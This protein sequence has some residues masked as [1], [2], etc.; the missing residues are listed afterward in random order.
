MEK[1]ISVDDS[2]TF[3]P[4]VV[5]KNTLVRNAL[6]VMKKYKIRHLPVVEKNRVIGIV[7]E[8]DVKSLTKTSGASVEEIMVAHPYRVKRGQLLTEVAQ[9]MAEKKYG[10]AIIENDKNEVIGIFT[11]TDALFLLSRL[12]KESEYS[13][14]KIEQINWSKFPKYM[15]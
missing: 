1:K 12:L 3:Y 7:S 9:K 5:F 6:S 15:I 2:M 8:R 4:E 14:L 10:C 11:T 13:K